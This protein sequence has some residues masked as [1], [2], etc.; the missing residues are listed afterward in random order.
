LPPLVVKAKSQFCQEA[1]QIL[2]V[3]LHRC[4]VGSEQTPQLTS[5]RSS[6]VPVEERCRGTYGRFP[7]LLLC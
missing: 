1:F 7:P 2:P 6:S 3:L 4:S 5:M